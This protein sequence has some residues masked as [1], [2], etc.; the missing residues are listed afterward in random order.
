MRNAM[1]VV[2]LP[3]ALDVEH[4]LQRREDVEGV[5]PEKFGRRRSKDRSAGRARRNSIACVPKAAQPRDEEDPED[6]RRGNMQAVIESV[7]TAM[8][9]AKIASAD[10]SLEDLVSDRSPVVIDTEA[11]R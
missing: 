7:V 1:Q 2:S 5:C 10:D 3:V 4:L 6:Q 11:P 8:V 9:N